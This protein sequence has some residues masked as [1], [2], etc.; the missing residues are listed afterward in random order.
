M[1]EKDRKQMRVKF[2]SPYYLAKRE[3]P[4]RYYPDLLNLQ[5]K[6]EIPKFG[7]SYNNERAAA[8]FTEYVAEVEKKELQQAL[9]KGCYFSVL[10][11]W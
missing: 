9:S 4:F 6:N 11:E 7:E 1:A 5:A 3:R 2:N 8:L 10:T